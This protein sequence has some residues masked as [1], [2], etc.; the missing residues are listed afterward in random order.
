M[1]NQKKMDISKELSSFKLAAVYTF[2]CLLGFIFACSVISSGNDNV[3]ENMWF[4]A[5]KFG[6]TLILTVCGFYYTMTIFN[7]ILKVIIERE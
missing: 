4:H 5:I 7:R 6:V 1:E 3:I 2:I